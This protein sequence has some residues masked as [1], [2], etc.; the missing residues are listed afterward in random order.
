MEV[1]LQ[2]EGEEEDF[3]GASVISHRFGWPKSESWW[4]VVGDT[5]SNTVLSI[6]RLTIP[7]QAKV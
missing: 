7:F 1:A 2:R 6:K 3:D 5:T 4:L